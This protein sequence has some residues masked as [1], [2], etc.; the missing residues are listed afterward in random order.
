MIF[1]STLSSSSLLLCHF[2]KSFG[3]ADKSSRKR[4][5]ATF[6]FQWITLSSIILVVNAISHSW[7]PY[8]LFSFAGRSS[9]V[10]TTGSCLKNFLK[11]IMQESSYCSSMFRSL[12]K[13]TEDRE[14]KRPDEGGDKHKNL[15]YIKTIR[16]VFSHTHT[17]TVRCRRLSVR[18][19]RNDKHS[20]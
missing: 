6:S 16:N 9:C 17:D 14:K 7:S 11:K 19:L 18:L 10:R 20:Q 2:C 13:K 8:F 5:E 4:S 3:C 15:V 1:W 12:C